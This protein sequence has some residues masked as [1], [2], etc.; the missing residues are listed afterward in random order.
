MIQSE[1]MKSKKKYKLPLKWQIGQMSTHNGLGMQS[2]LALVNE[3]AEF[4]S[5][6]CQLGE[7][8]RSNE[9]DSYG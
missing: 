3:G 8:C 4:E 5:R 9:M 7:K 6:F 1:S 2:R